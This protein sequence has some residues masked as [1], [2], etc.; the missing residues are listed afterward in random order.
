MSLTRLLAVLESAGLDPQPRE[1]AEA[2]WLAPH[3]RPGAAPGS[4][5]DA[6]RYQS[7]TGGRGVGGGPSAA[8]PG[9][10]GGAGKPAGADRGRPDPAPPGDQHPLR[11]P[12]PRG[13]ATGEALPLRLPAADALPG[14][15]ALGRALRPLKRRVPDRRRLAVDEDLTATRIAE[16]GMWL[17][18]LRP[19]T[20]RW[21]DLALVVDAEPSMVAWQPLIAELRALLE[22]LGAFRDVRTWSLH[23][24]EGGGLGLSQGTSRGR[25]RPPAELADPTGRRLILLVSDCVGGPWHSGVVGALLRRWARGGPVAILQPLPQRLWPRTGL[26]PVRG[27]LH[28]P[29][30]GVPNARLRFT[31]HHRRRAASRDAVPVPV[32]Q[33]EPDWLAPWARLIGADGGG[34]MDSAVT[35]AAPPRPPATTEPVRAAPSRPADQVTSFHAAATPDA[36]RLASYLAAVPLN[37][38]IMRLVQRVMLPASRPSHLAEVLLSGLLV[39]VTGGED[40]RYEF[41]PGVREELAGYLLR[42]QAGRLRSE[43]SRFFAE[44]LGLSP[45]E[46]RAAVSTPEG[47]GD[48]GLAT[49]GPPLGHL[50]SA[51]LARWGGRYRELTALFE[52]DG[53]PR[54]TEA[55]PSDA[56]RAEELAAAAEHLLAP[57]WA[58]LLGLDDRP[59][60]PG[61]PGSGAEG[62]SFPREVLDDVEEAIRLYRQ[63]L[64]IGGHR[65]RLLAGLVHALRIRHELTNSLA[66]LHE[67]LAIGGQALDLRVENGHLDEA[68]MC[69]D[70]ADLRLV[71]FHQGGK[72]G[73]LDEAVRL[74]RTAVD[75]T[76]HDDPARSARYTALARALRLRF[77]RTRR[78][79]DLDE[80]MNVYQQALATAGSRAVPHLLAELAGTLRTRFE[81]AG[82][83]R[84]L[85]AAL[86]TQRRAVDAVTDDPQRWRFIADLADLLRMRFEAGG[87]RRDLDEAV[88]LYR[89]VVLQAPPGAGQVR[90]LR[91]LSSAA[92]TRFQH[93]GE[94]ADLDE[95]VDLNQRAAETSSVGDPE[96]ARNLSTMSALLRTRF[97]RGGH[98]D[99]LD[100]AVRAARQA[101]EST[102]SYHPDHV[103]YLEE[104][105][106]VARI[107]FE[108]VG[109]PL[110]LIEAIDAFQR[111]ADLVPADHP[112]RARYL[113]ELGAALRLQADAGLT[114]GDLGRAVRVLAEA[115]ALT[116]ADDPE[117]PRRAVL[118][119]RARVLAGLPPDDALAA[120]HDAIRAS[121]RVLGEDHPDILRARLELGRVLLRAGH[122]AE[123]AGELSAASAASARVLGAEHPT[124]LAARFHHA[125]ALARQRRPAEAARELAEVLEIQTRVLG[126]EHPDTVA[127]RAALDALEQPR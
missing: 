112:G 81:H 90:A 50:P 43:L 102:P 24:T 85:D 30:A 2:L 61:A 97:E 84:D 41:A 86:A 3:L 125:G 106:R 119:A 82:S 96:H 71:R 64:A 18:V 29:A 37:L 100:R 55:S 4:G 38:P 65:A 46:F 52:V 75:L 120:C 91:A 49:A 15:L 23:P 68:A 122:L 72:A 9:G 88:S 127:S 123:A 78:L 98:L 69:A 60:R 117:Y 105:G 87:T 20:D 19:A 76:R 44:R 70:L 40:T 118:L 27:R 110:D 113:T 59:P 124:T 31:R 1:V 36:F 51:M 32:L 12:A 67:A 109:D 104:L 35:F 80:A 126:A 22:N 62:G 89:M 103:G 77:D 108:A 54:Q 47:T 6:A 17:P 45:R 83:P 33:I 93:T 94:A 10:A 8:L 42:S 58:E 63:A 56:E 101:L 115:V 92:A 39:T 74:S 111:A 16:E 13:T 26:R 14:K 28:A 79:N 34:W 48:A 11:L 121:A 7:P 25:L 53:R 95:A 116:S 57:A 5:E 114:G 66:D 99:D 21:L 107:R 73:D